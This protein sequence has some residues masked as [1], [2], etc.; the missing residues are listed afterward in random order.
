MIIVDWIA[1]SN[2]LVWSDG[3][4]Y[5]EDEPSPTPSAGRSAGGAAEEFAAV[6]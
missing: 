1:F 4:F 2:L 5:L 6:R 3:S